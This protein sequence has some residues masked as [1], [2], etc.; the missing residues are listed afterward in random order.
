MTDRVDLVYSK[1]RI[2]IITLEWYPG[3]DSTSNLAG[4]NRDMDASS[5][6]V[7]LSASG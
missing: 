5:F 2:Y 4:S 7:N 6:F 3:L 1:I